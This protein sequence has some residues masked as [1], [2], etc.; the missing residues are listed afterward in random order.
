[1]IKYKNPKLVL[2]DG[3]SFDNA[4]YGQSG[5]FLWIT[6]PGKTIAEITPIVADNSKM[7]EIHAYYL[8]RH[9]TFKGFTTLN[10]IRMTEDGSAV[11]VRM[12]ANGENSIEEAFVTEDDPE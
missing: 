3:S 2:K 11:E 7:S 10:L 5:N 6:F 12:A 8:N 4:P 1:M 9:I